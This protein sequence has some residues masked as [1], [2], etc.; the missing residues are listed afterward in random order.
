MWIIGWKSARVSGLSSRLRLMF[1]S[2][3]SVSAVLFQSCRIRALAIFSKARSVNPFGSTPT[4][5]ANSQQ[6]S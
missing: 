1:A 6:W 5:P 4:I 2:S 3:A